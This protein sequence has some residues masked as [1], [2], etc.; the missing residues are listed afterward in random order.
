MGLWLTI[1]QVDTI[2]VD[3]LCTLSDA[4]ISFSRLTLQQSK[5]Q[6]FDVFTQLKHVKTHISIAG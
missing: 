2:P 6:H 5:T 1:N 4:P 3:D